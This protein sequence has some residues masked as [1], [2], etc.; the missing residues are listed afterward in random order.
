MDAKMPGTL[1][2]RTAVG[3]CDDI[4]TRWRRRDKLNN[5]LPSRTV[6]PVVRKLKRRVEDEGEINRPWEIIS[7]SARPNASW[8]R[9]MTVD[10]SCVEDSEFVELCGGQQIWEWN[11]GGC[12]SK[13]GGWGNSGVCSRNHQSWCMAACTTPQSRTKTAEKLK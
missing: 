5:T 8:K 10:R 12:G 9:F 1:S 13:N 7:V 2:G 11:Y 3:T 4:K 6:N